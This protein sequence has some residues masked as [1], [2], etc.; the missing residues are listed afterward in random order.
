MR[1]Q[2]NSANGV[3]VG[4]N[5]CVF[6][7]LSTFLHSL[8]HQKKKKPLT[9]EKIKNRTDRTIKKNCHSNQV[10]EMCERHECADGSGGGAIG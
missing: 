4:V 9:E 7:L 8:T 3:Y 10:H 2:N 5:M 1:M 6:F